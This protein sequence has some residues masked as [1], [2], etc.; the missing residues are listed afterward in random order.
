MTDTAVAAAALGLAAV[1]SLPDERRYLKIR[2][3]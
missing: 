3:M 2:R 1:R